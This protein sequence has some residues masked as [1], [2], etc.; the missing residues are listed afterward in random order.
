MS[1]QQQQQQTQVEQPPQNGKKVI[2]WQDSSGEL[3]LK[4][5]LI[6]GNVNKND[7]GVKPSTI[8][9]I[10]KKTAVGQ[11]ITLYKDRGDEQD[12]FKHKRVAGSYNHPVLAMPEFGDTIHTAIARQE[13]AAVGRIHSIQQ[14]ADGDWYWIGKLTDPQAKQAFASDSKMPF[15]TSPSI[16]INSIQPSN[17]LYG[18]DGT[19]VDVD[20]SNPFAQIEDWQFMHIA[21]VDTPAYGKQAMITARCS[22]DA[23][24]CID[25]L[26]YASESKPVV[27]DDHG[28]C[29]CTKQGM[30]ELAAN[31]R[32]AGLEKEADHSDTSRISTGTQ[33][34][35]VIMSVNE[36]S[37]KVNEK[38]TNEKKVVEEKTTQQNTQQQPQPQANQNSPAEKKEQVE[39][40]N[41]QLAASLIERLSGENQKLKTLLETQMELTKST[42]QR[43]A[44]VEED[45]KKQ[46]EERRIWGL[47]NV[48]HNSKIHKHLPLEEQEKLVQ[49]YAAAQMTEESLREFIAPFETANAVHYVKEAAAPTQK[50][51]SS[52]SSQEQVPSR[53]DYPAQQKV[54]SSDDSVVT[55]REPKFKL[56]SKHLK[57]VGI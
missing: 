18:A 49:K 35:P 11:P 1:Q 20:R 26:K 5:F 3:W 23:S 4:G 6:N 54:A 22:G 44:T 31:V 45:L 28:A 33:Q 32:K 39:S 53:L 16:W 46:S 56:I 55:N 37:E 9:E 47:A 40:G 12:R 17:I 42:Q 41:Q 19:P 7:W 43:L 27:T 51:A 8:P 15:F 13:A 38:T 10:L 34:D 25:H 14:N 50:V 52:S 30:N 2:S 36:N 48:V 57:E 21:L 29:G 24:T